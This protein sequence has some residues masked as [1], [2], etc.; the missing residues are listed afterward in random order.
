VDPTQN[1]SDPYEADQSG[2]TSMNELQIRI[3]R[4]KC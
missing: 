1:V 2:E 3:C 4:Q